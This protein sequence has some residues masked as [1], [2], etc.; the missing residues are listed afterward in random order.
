MIVNEDIRALK[1]AFKSCFRIIK[2]GGG[3]VMNEDGK[4]LFIKRRG[5]WDL[6]KGK[7]EKFENYEATALREVCEE[8]SLQHPHVIKRIAVTWHTYRINDKPILKKTVWFL[9]LVNNSEHP[10]PQLSEEITEVRWFGKE[11]LE[12]VRTNTFNSIEEVVN[13]I[14]N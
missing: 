12:E 11:E 4:Y 6:P 9:M 8:C 5:V 7:M 10:E 2:A 13:L 14:L 3:L 1:K